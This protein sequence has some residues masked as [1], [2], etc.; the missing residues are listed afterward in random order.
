[1]PIRSALAI[2]TLLLAAAGSVE[3]SSR[4]RIC[5]SRSSATRKSRSSAWSGAA[6]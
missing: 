2:V 6:P 3:R 4:V 5:G 1:M